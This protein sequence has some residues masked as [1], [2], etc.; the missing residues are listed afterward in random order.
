MQMPLA[1]ALLTPAMPVIRSPSFIPSV[2]PYQ[3]IVT[4]STSTPPSVLTLPR[5][6]FLVQNESSIEK[7][8][9]TAAGA[10]GASVGVEQPCT[11][12]ANKEEAISNEM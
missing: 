5:H 7:P 4:L 1:D 3:I 8:R 2:Y 11:V 10:L 12:I 9:Q 6:Q